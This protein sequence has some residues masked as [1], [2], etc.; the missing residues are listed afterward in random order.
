MLFGDFPVINQNYVGYKCRYGYIST[1]VNQKREE[2]ATPDFNGFYKY[3]L[4]KKKVLGRVI[5]E[6]GYQTGEVYF[7]EREGAS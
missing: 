7:Q 3:D 6:K 2:L 1:F 5:L 4:E